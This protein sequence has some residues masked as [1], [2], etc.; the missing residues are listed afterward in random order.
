MMSTVSARPAALLGLCLPLLAHAPAASAADPTQWPPM[1]KPATTLSGALLDGRPFAE[2][3]PRIEVF[4]PDNGKATA[5]A[6]TIRTVLGYSTAPLYGLSASAEMLAVIPMIT[7]YY[8]Q[9]NGK[10]GFAQINDPTGIN[11]GQGYLRYKSAWGLDVKAGR[12]VIALDDQRFFGKSDFR[13]SYQSID[14]VLVKAGPVEG[15]SLIG[16][17]GWAVKNSLNNDAPARVIIAQGSYAP[18]DAIAADGFAYYYANQSEMFYTDP[19]GTKPIGFATC[20][21]KPT[22]GKPYLACNNQ[23]AGGRLH[24][25]FPIG[26]ASLSYKLTYAHQSPYAGGSPLIDADLWQAAAELTWRKA[27]FTAQY[28]VMG[29]NPSGTYGFQ[30]ALSTR[31]NFNG[32]AEVF[33]TTPNDGLRTFDASVSLPWGRNTFLVRGFDFSSDARNVHDGN[34]IDLSWSYKFTPHITGALEYGVYMPDRYGV[35]TNL[36]YAV[37]TVRY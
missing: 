7:S 24:G 37:M 5:L 19:A 17:W 34:E 36:A 8:S 16:G 12:Q 33:N 9:A 4:D 14:S 23:I 6:G 2:I 1:A 11:F 27:I 22:K 21:I 31:H 30:T 26:A 10:T 32:W 25:K 3:R 29:S 35:H 28:L 18:R 13:Q 20:G 15:V